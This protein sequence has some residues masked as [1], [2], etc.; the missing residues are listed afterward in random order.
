M[1]RDIVIADNS[2][3]KEREQ[4]FAPFCDIGCNPVLPESN[5]LAGSKLESALTAFP[6]VMKF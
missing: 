1:T 2:L 6:T 3:V 4:A 5:K